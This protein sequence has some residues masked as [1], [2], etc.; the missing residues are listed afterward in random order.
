MP[1]DAVIGA[2]FGYDDDKV[3]PFLKSLRLSG[4]QGEIRLIVDE[5]TPLSKEL[6]DTYDARRVIV[7][8]PNFNERP[9]HEGRYWGYRLVLDRLDVDRVLLSDVR[10]VLFQADPFRFRG[11]NTY[12][13]FFALEEGTIAECSKNQEWITA[14]YGQAIFNRLSGYISVCSGTTIGTKTA[15]VEYVDKMCEHMQHILNPPAMDQGAHNY[16]C[17]LDPIRGQRLMLNGKSPIMTVGGMKHFWRTEDGKLQ[18]YNQTIP[19]TVH[20]YDRMHSDLLGTFS[21][22]KQFLPGV[23]KHF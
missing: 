17:Y 7:G 3:R 5:A 13:I 14:R 6:V 10:D 23:S 19:A 21:Y 8:G 20:L 15:I 1:R 18:N 2:A 22:W 9:P 11:W 4:Y 16:I 12:R